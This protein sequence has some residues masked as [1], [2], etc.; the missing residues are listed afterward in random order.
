MAAYS[1]VNRIDVLAVFG[2]GGEDTVG[3][4]VNFSFAVA[5]FLFDLHDTGAVDIIRE[6]TRAQASS[7]Q[8]QLLQ[9]YDRGDVLT[10]RYAQL[11][12]STGVL[13]DWVE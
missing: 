11:K 9:I 5:S 7:V 13:E 12:C 10:G 4:Q 3:M 1:F 6:S 8:G 2:E